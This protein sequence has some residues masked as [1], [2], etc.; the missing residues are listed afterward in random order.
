M[1]TAAVDATIATLWR[2]ES[3]RLIARLGRL[4]GDLDTAEELAQDTF[5]AAFE[6]WRADGIPDNPGAW[7]TTTSRYLAIDRI[8]R[9]DTGRDKLR[10]VA[11][12]TAATFEID[13]DRIVD[14]DL[15]DDLLGLVLMSCHPLL[16][17]DARSALV[18][19]LVC[20]LTTAEVARAFLAP[21]ATV[22]QRIV[23]AKRTL[24]AANI[25]FELPSVEQ[26]EERLDGVREVIYL[27]FNEGYAASS[28]DAW[29]RTD[30]CS[31]ALRLGRVL[32]A[33]T[34]HDP[35]SLG[36]LALMEI[37]TSRLAARVGPDGEQVLL[38]DQ[39][40]SRWDRL[41]IRRGLELIDRID[42]LRGTA[43]PYALQAAIAACHARAMTA[44]ETD[45]V[46]IA[47]LY[48]GLVQ[49]V[50]SPVVELNRAVAVGRAFGAEAGLE[51]VAP[52]RGL[53][54]LAG[55]HLLPAVAGDLECTAGRHEQAREDF[56]RAASLAGNTQDRATMQQ[57]AAECVV[58]ST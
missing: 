20:G 4:V 10:T 50:P 35:E 6:K 33:L 18:L 39:D 52:L 45:W 55:Y 15:A 42:D 2:V 25:R 14:G 54:S 37:Q 3:P 53:A 44:E 9:R 38:L 13:V 34:P 19:K 21:E 43:G 36:L 26:R 47:A 41:L 1:S 49:V 23:R 22:A 29:V 46:R 30:L 24:A 56:L 17:P 7:L 28:G 31:E 27:L 40:R 48:D 57:R 16:A 32:A 51:I 58:H 12:T 5:A 11:A 8:R